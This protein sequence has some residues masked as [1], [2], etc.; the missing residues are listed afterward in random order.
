M[1]A[2]LLVW[3]VWLTVRVYKYTTIGS[4]NR[5][6]IQNTVDGYQTDITKVVESARASMVTISQG[7]HE[8]S[9]VIVGSEKNLAYV[10]TSAQG[11]QS[12]SDVSVKFENTVC[13]DGTVAGED[14]HTG[15]ALIKVQP[16]FEVSPIQFGDSSLIKAGE[17][18]T[19]IGGRRD[20]DSAMISSGTVSSVVQMPINK[21][22]T[23]ICNLL[24]ADIT[25]T[26]ENIGGALL[27]LSGELEGII[28]TKPSEG[29]MD[30]GYAVA[31]N[32]VR[33]VFSELKTD[34]TV[35]LGNLGVI[36]RSIAKMTSYEKNAS[37]IQLDQTSGIYVT[38]IEKDSP[39]DSLMKA[40]DVINSI[41]GKTV[42]SEE[43]LH[44]LLYSHAAGDALIITITR[45][46]SVQQINVVLK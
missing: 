27:N 5:T 36:G 22:T 19:A 34:G 28:V 38:G 21:E 7:S 31:M 39:A 41:D 33:N 9:G 45:D 3:N 17:I 29:Q 24:E 4:D 10:M 46:G 11:L 35:T 40:G 14:I 44:T 26:E 8:C 16:S 37:S 18:V 2:A 25:V 20:T 32:E 30:M 42:L 43:D 12:N 13:V 1:L 6:V 15:L 23:W